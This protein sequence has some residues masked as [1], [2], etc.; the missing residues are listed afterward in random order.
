MPSIRCRAARLAA[1]LLATVLLAAGCGGGGGSSGGGAPISGKSAGEPTHAVVVQGVDPTTMDPLQQRETTTVNVL[2]HLYDTLIERNGSDPQKFEPVLAKSWKQVNPTTLRFTLRKGVKFSGGETFGPD[3]VK[4]TVDYLLGKLPGRD[5]AILSYQYGTLEGAKVVGPDTV[6]IVTKGPDPLLLSRMAAL[7]IVPK[8]AVDKDRKALAGKPD[9]TG[10]YELVRWDRNNQVVMRA[11]PDYYRGRPAIDQVTFKTMPDASSRLAA[12]QAG[13]VDLV[14]GV[15]ADNIQDVEASGNATVESV[16]S[17]RIASVW[18][19][20]LDSGPLK[21]PAVR[22]ALNY[23]VDVPTI[24]K[25][26]MSGYGLP[27]A[28][29][30][31]PYFTNYDPSIKPLGYDP[32]KAKQLLAQAG[33]PNG[34]SMEMMVPQGRYEFASEVT[35]AVAGYLGKVGV[36]VK[37]DNV[38]FGVFAKA[39]QER[40]IPEAFY[41][42]WGEEYFNPIDELNVAVLSGT[43]GFSWYANDQADKLIA[44]ASAT[45]DPDKQRAIVSRIQRL[46]LDDPPFI[47]LF[48]YK[49]LYGISKRLD[50]KPRSDESVNMY[51]AKLKEP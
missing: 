21:K 27:V 16:N 14:T 30:V 12:L 1:P 5:P 49:D 32:N 19:N 31:P 4:Y 20:T 35:Q 44:Q 18:L 33:Y 6:D 47:F 3:D 36:K 51:E 43:K 42:A 2:Q 23:A 17:A 39:T 13:Q 48:A 8:G 22:Q 40:K 9:G 11:K 50:W 29:I 46:M 38:D 10:P 25:Q 28:T 41:G 37:L 34:F 45:L 26:V 7:M 24:V 15:P